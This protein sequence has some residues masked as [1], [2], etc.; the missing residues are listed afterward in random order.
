MQG[1]LRA[2]LPLLAAICLLG[3]QALAAD[4]ELGAF[5][6]ETCTACHQAD[7]RDSAIP[8]IAGMDQAKF[9]SLIQAYRSGM[10]TNSV[11]QAV[12]TSLSD[13]EIAALAHYLSTRGV[14]P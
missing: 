7:V 9:I 2:A 13:E 12:A 5:L 8:S 14:Q 4:D 3:P 6:S 1:S 10:R 11:M